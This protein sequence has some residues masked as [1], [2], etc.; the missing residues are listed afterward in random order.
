MA[1][2][3]Q[4][5]D[6][7]KPKQ[8]KTNKSKT[9]TGGSFKP[10]D[11]VHL[12]NHTHYSV[13]DGLQKTGEMVARAR[14]LGMEAI[15]MTDHG[16]LS[17]AIEFYQEATKAGIKPLI[18]MEAYVAPRGHLDKEGKQDANPYHLTLVAMNQQ[19]YENLMRLSTIANTE[20]FYYKPRVDRKL[21]KRYN[22]GLIVLSGCINGEVG[23]ALRRDQTELAVKAAK[24]HQQ[25]FGDR[26]YL[27]LQDHGHQWKVQGQANK[28]LLKL[29]QQLGIGCVVT[30]DAH[31]TYKEDQDAHEVLLCVQTGSQLDDEKRMSLRD[32][33]LFLSDP[34]AIAERWSHHPEVLT[35]TKQI[36]D[37][38]DV[39]IEFGRI[40]IPKFDPPEGQTEKSWLELLTYQGLAT[41]YGGIAPAKSVNYDLGKAKQ[42]LEEA[43]IERAEFELGV[44]NK[45]GF[46]DFFLIF[47]DLVKWGKERGIVFGPGRGSA[48]GSIVSYALGVTDLDPIKYDLLFE[49]FLNPDRIS[50]P[51]IDID[52][53]D[54]RR[55]EVIDYVIERYGRDRVAHI[56]TFG[57]MAA[58]NAIR[59]VARVLGVAYAD[60][61]RLAKMVP[62]PTQGR[63]TPLATHIKQAAELKEE[64]RSN[65]ESKRVIDLAIRLEGTIRSHGVHAAGVVIA[66]DDIVKY[67]PLEKAQKGVIATQYSMY[68]IEELGLLKMDFL[69]LSNLTI[70]KNALRIVRKVHGQDIDIG[71]IPLDDEQ[72]FELLRRGETRGIFQFESRGMRRYMKQLK[73]SKFDDLTALAALF[74]P[75][76]LAAGY[77]D[78]FIATKNGE[79]QVQY[80]HPKMKAALDNT[81]GVL[82]YQ[83]QVMQIA[84]DMCG[85]TGGQADTLRKAI[86][87]KKADL[88]AQ[89]KKEFIEGMVEHSDVSS[90]FAE[91]YWA[92]LEGFADYCFNKSHSAC[93]AMIAYQTAYLKAHFPE[94][95]MAAL[96]TSNF[97][98]NERVAQDVADCRHTGIEVLPPDINE[99]FVEFGVVPGQRQIRFALS[100]IKNVGVGTVE[101]IL[102]AR[103][104]DGPFKSVGDFIKRVSGAEINRKTLDSL[105]RAG[106]LDSLADRAKLLFNMD[107]LVAYASKVQKEAA[108]QQAGLFGA[109]SDEDPTLQELTLAEPPEEVSEREQ[110]Q[111]ERELLGLYLS[112]HPLDEAGDWLA[113][114]T[115]PISKITTSQEGQKVTVGGIV[116][117]VRKIVTRNG[118]NM[119]FVAIEDTSDSLELIVFPKAFEATPELW[120]TDK[121]VLATGRVSSKDRDGKQTTEIKILVDK[122]EEVTP[123][124]IKRDQGTNR[125]PRPP[126]KSSGS[127]VSD[128]QPGETAGDARPQKILIKLPHTDNPTQLNKLKE[129]LSHYPGTSDVIL[130]VNG[131]TRIKLP[132]KVEPTQTLREQ[133]ETIFSKQAVTVSAA[134]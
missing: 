5:A 69:G 68:P 4:P 93:Y 66:P 27:E 90:K 26:Y 110:L 121:V 65:P 13:L 78:D 33:D 52:I 107:N 77:T 102:E 43:V 119:A 62:P 97:E 134:G 10:S 75:G 34:W 95:F 1:E 105:V 91:D 128:S 104:Q 18:G 82:V 60:A 76:P 31:Y 89:M 131:G 123:E 42:T 106:A 55:D 100:A 28:Q 29:G 35:N 36:A 39:E 74:R 80:D 3:K 114:H 94:A 118:A 12:H 2:T 127:P 96:M 122:A 40:L 11:F 44:I 48:A 115:T 70:I 101:K 111:W 41:R 88:M 19:G 92:K 98:D 108:T 61:D 57:K 37:R 83:E 67:T 17:G 20:G 58:R 51:D 56:V 73:P 112:K 8:A 113:S 103:E 130:I 87:K 125:K 45:M 79:R 15:A 116:T 38:C 32:M 71:T 63:H 59:D 124:L 16:T 72:T 6:S 132:F 86:G 81:Y 109:G 54:S 7:P 46:A 9:K 49:R 129:V 117:A 47:W 24:W 21:L 120:Q 50:M 99:S 22:E 14:E 23:D 30:S 53:M 85:F 25:I 133:L 64:Y 126:A 84:K